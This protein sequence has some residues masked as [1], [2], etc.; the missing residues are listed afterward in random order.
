MKD[1]FLVDNLPVHIEGE[2]CFELEYFQNRF[3]IW[4]PITLAKLCLCPCKV[5]YIRNSVTNFS[6]C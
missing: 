3:V 6:Q 4:P 2:T 5:S 1:D